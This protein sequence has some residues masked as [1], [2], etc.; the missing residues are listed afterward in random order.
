M[1]PAPDWRGDARQRAFSCSVRENIALAEPTA[2]IEKIMAVAE[3]AG[4]HE[5]ISAL[6]DGYET[7]LHERGEN[8][9]GGLKAKNRYCT[10]TA[11]RSQNLILDEA[12][13]HSMQNPSST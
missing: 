12:T 7:V 13:M 3:L 2:P 4:A 9:S 8:L 10:G 6:A 11:E 1:A 5:F